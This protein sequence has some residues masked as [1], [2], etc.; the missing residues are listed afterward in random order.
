MDISNIIEQVNT[1]AA[2]ILDVR[3]DDEWSAGHIKGAV[4]YELSRIE[5]GEL[6][7]IPKDTTIYTHCRSGGR[8]TRAQNILAEAGFTNVVCVG[9]YNDWKHAGGDVVEN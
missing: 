2:I 9:G 4:H 1:N 6:P 5:N 3:T 8:A 7:A